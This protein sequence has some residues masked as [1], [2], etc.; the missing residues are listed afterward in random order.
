M[1]TKTIPKKN[2]RPTKMTDVVKRKALHLISTTTKSVKQIC[3]VIKV[4][5]DTFFDCLCKDAKFSEQYTRAKELQAEVF[6]YELIDIAR[7]KSVDTV[8]AMDK[9]IEID[10]IKWAMSKTLPKKYGN[11]QQVTLR[12]QDPTEPASPIIIKST[13]DID[14]S[15]VPTE[16]LEAFLASQNDK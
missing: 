15:K 3:K 13:N 10:T 11:A 6:A 16:V 1:E 8:A 12:G 14:I 2:G 9:R 7:K 5:Q 4:N